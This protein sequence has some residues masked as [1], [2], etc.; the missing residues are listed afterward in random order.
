MRDNYRENK[1]IP[2]GAVVDTGPRRAEHER[3][4]RKDFWKSDWFLGLGAIAVLLL[5]ATDLVG[6]P[7]RKARDFGGPAFT[8]ECG[9]DIAAITNARRWAGPADAH[10]HLIESLRAAPVKVTG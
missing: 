9:G 4:A 5:S 1:R 7:E 3:M 8:R 6:S 2:L 10:A